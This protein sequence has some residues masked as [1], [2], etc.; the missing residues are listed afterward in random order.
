LFIAGDNSSPEE[1]QDKY[2][3][4][5]VPLVIEMMIVSNKTYSETNKVKEMMWKLRFG[6][7]RSLERDYEREGLSNKAK[8]IDKLLKNENDSN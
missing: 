3:F 6:T 7:D 1:I 4:A 8:E 5:E 2:D